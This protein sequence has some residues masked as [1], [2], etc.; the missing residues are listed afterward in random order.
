MCF[1]VQNPRDNYLVG[2]AIEYSCIDGYYISG[3]RMAT[4]TDSQSWD[5]S[6]MECKRREA[7]ECH[8]TE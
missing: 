2:T 3:D 4:C 8:H 6:D 1:F 7:S 5:S